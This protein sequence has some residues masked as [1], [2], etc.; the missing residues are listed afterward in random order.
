M[1]EFLIDA[2]ARV[3]QRR[4][5]PL[6]A[7]SCRMERKSWSSS[8]SLGTRD[9]EK[10]D[11]KRNSSIEKAFDFAAGASPFLSRRAVVSGSR[12]A[13]KL[14]EEGTRIHFWG[15]QGEGSGQIGGQ[16]KREERRGAEEEVVEGRLGSFSTSSSSRPRPQLLT[17]LFSLSLSKPAPPPHP[18]TDPRAQLRHLWLRRALRRP[19]HGPAGGRQVHRARGQGAFFLLCFDFFRRTEK[20][21]KTK[22]AQN[23][24]KSKKKNLSLSG[25]QVRRARDPQ[26]P[27]AD[28][29]SRRAVQGGLPDAQVP[30]DRDGVCLWR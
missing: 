26:P 16:W 24:S 14:V 11:E 7:H 30:G 10:V 17:F 4:L 12:R 8:S 13:P 29:P 3:C 19:R 1:S 21:P 27:H 25:H 18:P 20:N 5:L 28:A 23:F 15:L 2:R 6:D 9:K 22:K